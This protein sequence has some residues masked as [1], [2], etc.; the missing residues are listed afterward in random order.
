MKDATGSLEMPLLMLDLC[1]GLKGASESMKRRGWS[2]IT[3]DNDPSFS[4]DI[5]A[6]VKTWNYQG[7]RPTLIWASPP[8]QEFSR[9]FFVWTRTG[10]KPDLS[11]W[12]GCQR[13]I[14]QANPRYWVIENTRGAP[15]YFGRPSAIYYP[16]YLWGFFPPLGKVDLSTRRHKESYASTD[17]ASRAKLPYAL[18]LALAKAIESAL[19]LVEV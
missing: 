17:K 4:P 14:K 13:I 12:Y 8:C 15:P 18:S 10:Q 9:E 19:I 3:L 11:I 5:L 16:Y 1:C 6:D 2:V 7:E